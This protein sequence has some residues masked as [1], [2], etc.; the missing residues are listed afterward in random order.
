MAIVIGNCIYLHGVSKEKFLE[1]WLFL[2]NN[3]LPVAALPLK[4][5]PTQLQGWLTTWEPIIYDIRPKTLVEKIKVE[6]AKEKATEQAKENAAHKASLAGKAAAKSV[7]QQPLV[8]PWRKWVMALL[9]IFSI[10]FLAL[11]LGIAWMFKPDKVQALYQRMQQFLQVLFTKSKDLYTRLKA[12][13]ARL[14]G[15]AAATDAAQPATET[16]QTAP[17]PTA[18][19]V[20]TPATEAPTI[21]APA[22]PVTDTEPSPAEVPPAPTVEAAPMLATDTSPPAASGDALPPEEATSPSEAIAVEKTSAADAISPAPE[23][24]QSNTKESMASVIP[25]NA[26]ES[27]ITGPIEPPDNAISAP[28]ATV[29]SEPTS[30]STEQQSQP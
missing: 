5:Y 22:T 4:Q 16:V 23:T 2:V 13:K 27:T 19:A 20:P 30:D 10:L 24:T 17:A 7:V 15:K 11:M 14:P 28:P 1:E 25:T 3:D 6:Q 9:V 18:E 26:T 21:K 8:S 29:H 12:L